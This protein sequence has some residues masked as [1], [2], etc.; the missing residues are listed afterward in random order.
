MGPSLT[1]SKMDLS[2]FE[3]HDE[4]SLT[5]SDPLAWKSNSR[6]IFTREHFKMN[7]LLWDINGNQ[8]TG[9]LQLK[10]LY[11][12]R[13]VAYNYC[14]IWGLTIS[15]EFILKYALINFWSLINVISLMPCHDYKSI[16]HQ[17]HMVSVNKNGYSFRCKINCVVDLILL[18]NDYWIKK[19]NSVLKYFVLIKVWGLCPLQ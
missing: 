4:L 3:S 13:N 15:C 17:K 14:S 10:M 18:C 11:L 2:W 6:H 8:P 16:F 7:I 1:E 19:Y 12:L 9:Q 5:A